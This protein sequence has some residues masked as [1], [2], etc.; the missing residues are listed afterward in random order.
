[1][2]RRLNGGYRSFTES[3]KAVTRVCQRSTPVTNSCMPAGYSPLN[4][5]TNCATKATTHCAMPRKIRM[6]PCGMMARNLIQKM[7]STAH[8]RELRSG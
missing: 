2:G 3:T 4:A 7:V 6:M 8:R 1:M 5:T